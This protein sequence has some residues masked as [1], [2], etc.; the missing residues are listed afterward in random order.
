MGQSESKKGE[1]PKREMLENAAKSIGEK[2]VWSTD[3]DIAPRIASSNE[4]FNP[5]ADDAMA[6]RLQ[7]GNN[8][9]L[10]FMGNGQFASAKLGDIY[11]LEKVENHDKRAAGRAAIVKVA[12]ERGKT[13]ID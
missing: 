8:I 12:A 6:F 4:T 1:M 11:E 9:E 3:E 2:L 5:Q 7:V 13:I 10:G